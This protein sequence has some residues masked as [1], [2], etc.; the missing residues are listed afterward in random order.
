M[1]CLGTLSFLFCVFDQTRKFTGD[2]I[3]VKYIF[4]PIV[5]YEFLLGH[6]LSIVFSV[7][8]IVYFAKKKI[9]LKWFLV[10]MFLHI[11][12]SVYFFSICISPYFVILRMCMGYT[13]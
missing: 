6:I 3:Y 5:Y 8:L 7:V 1:F 13:P 10:N 12:S 4:Q 2:N 9:T 11:S